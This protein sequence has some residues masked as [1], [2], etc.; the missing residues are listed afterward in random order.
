[1]LTPGEQP[2]QGT[3]YRLRATAHY[4]GSTARLVRTL[5][6]GAKEAKVRQ[7]Y[8]APD[9]SSSG[10]PRWLLIVIATAAVALLAPGCGS[11]AAGFAPAPRGSRRCGARS[12]KRA[13][14]RP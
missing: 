5:G 2:A 11:V 7:E 13:R 4:P 6:F 8:G 10:G 14:R 3:M 1:V 12:S 9:A